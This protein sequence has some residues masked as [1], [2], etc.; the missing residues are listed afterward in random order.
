MK[1]KYFLL[2]RSNWRERVRKRRSR[3]K[4]KWPE[5]GDTCDR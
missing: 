5:S 2:E 4:E 3:R 1:T